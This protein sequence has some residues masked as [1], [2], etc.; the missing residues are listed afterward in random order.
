MLEKI[1]RRK[2]YL[3]K[4]LE[5]PLLKEREDYLS[6]IAEKGFSHVTLLHMAEYLLLIVQMLGMKD[7]MS[8]KVKIED[9]QSAAKQWA[10]ALKN[11]TMKRQVRE[12]SEKK[13]MNIA[14]CRLVYIDKIEDLYT[15]K[16]CIINRLFKRRHHK[17]RYLTYP[18]LSER[19]A[20]LEHWE[21]LGTAIY[22]LRELA[23]CHLYAIDLLHV[24]DGRMVSEKDLMQAA[25]EWANVAK[26]NSRDS[27]GQLWRKRFIHHVK[28]WC[29][30]MNKYVEPEDMF[31]MKPLVMNYLDWL[32]KEKG[33]SY[34]TIRTYYFILRTFALATGV[35]DMRDLTPVILDSFI[36]SQSAK[37]G[38]SRRSTA[39]VVSVLRGF[40]NY[41]ERLGLC[42]HLLS[43]ALSSPRTY[44]NE[45][46]PSFVPW[47]VVQAI[48]TEK[49]NGSGMAI[50]DYAVLLLL[51]VYGMRSS[52]VANLKLE[53]IDWQK[54][55]LYL[56]RAKNCKP[57]I[58]PLLPIVGD[59]LAR[60]IK[61]LRFNGNK[62]EYVFRA[63][64]APHKVLSTSTI[65]QIARSELDRH[66]V[67]IRHRGPHSFR[68]G[69]ATHLIN[70][71]YSLKEIADLLGHMR[72]DTTRIYAK[73]DMVSLREVA[74]MN[75]EELL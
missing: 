67:N 31:P 57:Q 64:R 5:A 26:N 65:Y 22:T 41:G 4:H 13:F 58:M 27:D 8:D 44:Q 25:D 2:W 49:K 70:T 30:F 55:R 24:D 39:G 62:S 74:D 73:V 35:D 40:F 6:L 42:Q 61:E 66:G 37:T 14:F 12:S 17:L 53:D 47:D 59:A 51:S 16:D 36:T 7:G 69:C 29:R 3:Q 18:M 15:S 21:R 28:D 10:H 11:H 45:D 33:C 32:K 48:L 68:H 56:H 19:I 63:L 34:W 54:E 50:R 60:Y 38:W 71:G 75:W 1:V 23:V 43:M 72:L 46:L 20:H 52:E 9:V